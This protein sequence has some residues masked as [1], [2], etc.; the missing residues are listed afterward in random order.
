MLIRYGQ[1]L[2]AFGT[3]GSQHAAT[4]LGSHSLTE[5]VLVHSPAVVGLECSFHLYFLFI[6]YFFPFGLQNYSFHLN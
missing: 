5:S 6:R 1:L 3:T 2:T 4:I